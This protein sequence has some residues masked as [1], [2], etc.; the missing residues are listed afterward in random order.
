VVATLRPPEQGGRCEL[1][2]NERLRVLT[3]A[4]ELGAEYVDLEFDVASQ[5]A[6]A[7]VRAAGARVIISRHDFSGMPTDLSDAWWRELADLGADIVKVV[8]TAR[9]VRD[10]LPVFRALHRADRPTIAIAMGDAGL[11]T[12][13]LALRAD[14]C[15]LTYAALETGGGTAPG[16]LS[17][18]DMRQ[19]YRAE[20]IGPGTRV[21]GLL[22]PHAEAERLAQYN[23]WFADDRFDG[24]AVPFL[25]LSDAPRIVEAYRELPVSG[26]HV[27]GA[28]LQKRIVAALDELDAKA[29]RHGKVNGVV[30]RGDGGLVG[31]WV[32]SPREQYAVW[33]SAG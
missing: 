30:R 18:D 25:A 1:P 4:A 2:A 6:Q 22:G 15:L 32:E 14:N 7:A 12:R 16:Q 33:R 29:R 3:K 27:H 21:Y 20:R 23:T 19:T 9:E 5:S 11:S 26:W 10:C 28:D 17:L 8:G 31:H 13:V 24:V